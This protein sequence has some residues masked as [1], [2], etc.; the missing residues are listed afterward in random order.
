MEFECVR[1]VYYNLSRP[2]LFLL[3]SEAE[4]H[5]LS[6][7]IEVMRKLNADPGSFESYQK[8][9]NSLYLEYAHSEFVIS[10]AIEIIFDQVSEH[11]GCMADLRTN[12]NS[13]LSFHSPSMNKISGTWEHGFAVYSMLW[14]H[15]PIVCSGICCA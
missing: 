9:L 2:L 1:L 6:F 4:S 15:R 3:Q 10:N 13:R 14:T 7:L 11:C 8:E 5:V 12:F